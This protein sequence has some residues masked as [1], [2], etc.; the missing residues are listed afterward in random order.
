MTR[1]AECGGYDAER[2]RKVLIGCVIHLP[3]LLPHNPLTRIR[4]IITWLRI[5]QDL[6]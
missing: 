6:R 5:L 3:H 1:K 4:C 2:A